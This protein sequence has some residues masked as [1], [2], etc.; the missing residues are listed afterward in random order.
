MKPVRKYETSDLSAVLYDSNTGEITFGVHS[1][2]GGGGLDLKCQSISDVSTI[3]FCE[4]II[5]TSL[6]ATSN[7]IAIGSS[8]G[9]VCSSGRFRQP[10]E[11][12]GS[13]S[14]TKLGSSTKG[15]M[16]SPSVPERQ[17]GLWRRTLMPSPSA[18][19]QGTLVKVA[20]PSPSVIAQET[21]VKVAVP[22][23]SVKA[24]DTPVKVRRQ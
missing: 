22:S 1:G 19:V 8:A 17:G 16:Q 9:G 12:P 18:V 10:I 15:P 3:G 11:F 6:P 2:A 5:L 7:S 24:Q 14:A 4:N 13:R 23:P 21:P 20:V